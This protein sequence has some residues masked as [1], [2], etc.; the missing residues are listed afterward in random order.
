MLFN[1]Q[2]LQTLD[3]TGEAAVKAD[4]ALEYLQKSPVVHLLEK[5]SYILRICREVKYYSI[6]P[7][8]LI[9]SN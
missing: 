3:S 1:K 6:K 9:T 8:C 5:K 2:K 4:K 7:G